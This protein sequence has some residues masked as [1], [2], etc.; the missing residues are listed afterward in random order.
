M[1]INSSL[2]LSNCESNKKG[3]IMPSL[4][5]SNCEMS[6]KCTDDSLEEGCKF[7]QHY[8]ITLGVGPLWW[9]WCAPCRI[10]CIHSQ[11]REPRRGDQAES[12]LCELP[13][14]TRG[15]IIESCKK[16]RIVATDLHSSLNWKHI[17][18]VGDGS[19]A[20]VSL[21]SRTKLSPTWRIEGRFRLPFGIRWRNATVQ[22]HHCLSAQR[23]IRS[24]DAGSYFH[25]FGLHGSTA[26]SRLGST[27]QWCRQSL[28]ALY[29]RVIDQPLGHSLKFN[30]S[31]IDSVYREDLTR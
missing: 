29:H 8:C 22:K 2:P 24:S 16:Q 19:M 31:M 1:S 9:S 14:C 23:Q 20:T 15:W 13:H 4:I 5:S 28:H 30:A 17:R 10:V 26:D 18:W 27:R 6:S 11:H 21:H 3:I 25:V 12:A 7:Q